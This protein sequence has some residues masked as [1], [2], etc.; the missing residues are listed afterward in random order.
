[1]HVDR[2]EKMFIIGSIIMVVIFA[3]AIAASSVA[4]GIQVPAPEMRVNPKLF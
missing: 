4:Y 1:M 2:Y 3:L